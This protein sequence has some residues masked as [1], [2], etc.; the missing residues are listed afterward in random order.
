[1]CSSIGG[2][3]SERP[4]PYALRSPMW[5]TAVPVLEPVTGVHELLH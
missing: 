3:E 2:C 4:N 1:M 5:G